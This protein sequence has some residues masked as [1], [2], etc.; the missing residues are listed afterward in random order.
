M[1]G[2]LF[3]VLQ[4]G[5]HNHRQFPQLRGYQSLGTQYIPGFHTRHKPKAGHEIRISFH[6]ERCALGCQSRPPQDGAQ[7][8]SLLRYTV[9]RT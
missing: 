8:L 9:A 1:L 3:L 7:L 6:P 4:R 2:I 5:D